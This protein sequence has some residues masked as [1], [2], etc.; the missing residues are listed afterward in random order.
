MNM[1]ILSSSMIIILMMLTQL[2]WCSISYSKQINNDTNTI[3]FDEKTSCVS[4]ATV[5]ESMAVLACPEKSKKNMIICLNVTKLSVKRIDIELDRISDNTIRI[6]IEKL[7]VEPF[8]TAEPYTMNV[9]FGKDSVIREIFIENIILTPYSLIA[10]REKTDRIEH[11]K[12]TFHDVIDDKVENFVDFK[13]EAEDPKDWSEY[14]AISPY[15]L[16]GSKDGSINLKMYEL[17]SSK[18]FLHNIEK[19]FMVVPP[20]NR[21]DLVI[22]FQLPLAEKN[23]FKSGARPQ[24]TIIDNKI[25]FDC[26]KCNCDPIS[27]RPLR[28]TTLF[29]FENLDLVGNIEKI[30]A[31]SWYVVR[32]C[33]IS[34]KMNFHHH[35]LGQETFRYSILRMMGAGFKFHHWDIYSKHPSRLNCSQADV[36]Q[37]IKRLPLFRKQ[38]GAHCYISGRGQLRLVDVE[39]SNTNLS[40]FICDGPP[41]TTLDKYAE[42]FN[43]RPHVDGE[44]EVLLVDPE[45]PLESTTLSPVSDSDQRANFLRLLIG[46][47]VLVGSSM[48]FFLIYYLNKRR[49]RPKVSMPPPIIVTPPS[50]RL[51]AIKSK[52]HSKTSRSKRITKSSKQINSPFVPILSKQKS[53]VFQDAK[54]L[55]TTDSKNV[56][57][58]ERGKSFKSYKSVKS[59]K[60]GKSHKSAKSPLSYG[61]KVDR[62]L[63][64]IS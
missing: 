64:R 21:G 42:E 30:I 25:R 28:G 19:K 32:N 50:N 55:K 57:P 40:Q 35:I 38:M 52:S 58:T 34:I 56:S 5:P 53:V 22:K 46:L 37:M 63:D 48:I 18:F 47:I 49:K 27:K 17:E 23:I 59:V 20:L 36:C 9:I 4:F 62:L 12:M 60:S 8:S 14:L 13:A 43:K 33:P 39:S 61:S 24:V 29:H 10:L 54:S 41:M 2:N 11:F 26:S 3:N 1:N 44:N 7:A 31:N 6:T 15:F 45:S 16:S 51:Q